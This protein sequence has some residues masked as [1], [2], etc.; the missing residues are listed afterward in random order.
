MAVSMAE[1]RA[2]LDP[3]EVDYAA[4][5]AALGPEAVP[6]LGELA[7]GPDQGLATKA[8]YLASLVGP[9]G[10]AIVLDALLSEDALRRVAGAAGLENLPAEATAPV[11]RLVLRDD[12][13]G[14]R[15]VAIRALARKRHPDVREQLELAARDDPEPVLRDLAGAAIKGRRDHREMRETT[16]S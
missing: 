11:A 1:V 10:H 7:S 15:K 16:E 12:D 6:L 3:E 4:A 9:E 8:I 14:V 13:V 5:A 2:Y